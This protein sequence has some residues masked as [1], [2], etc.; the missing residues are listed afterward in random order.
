MAPYRNKILADGM[1]C[2]KGSSK[3]SKYLSI[4]EEYVTLSCKN[5]SKVNSTRYLQIHYIGNVVLLK[6]ALSFDSLYNTIIKVKHAFMM[7]SN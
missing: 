4:P 7:K 6:Q 2:L 3:G 1:L 5:I